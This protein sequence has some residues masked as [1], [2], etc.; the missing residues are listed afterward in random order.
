[1]GEETAP[2]LGYTAGCELI[3]ADVATTGAADGTGANTVNDGAVDACTAGAAEDVDTAGCANVV[4]GVTTAPAGSCSPGTW[5]TISRGIASPFCTAT[6][7]RRARVS[8]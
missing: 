1:M 5:S 8:G 7:S 3:G 2:T 6:A 4:A